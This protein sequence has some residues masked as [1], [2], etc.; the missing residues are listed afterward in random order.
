[1]FLFP[2]ILNANAAGGLTVPLQI[3]FSS[4]VEDACYFTIG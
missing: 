2:Y 3:N 1:M 4:A